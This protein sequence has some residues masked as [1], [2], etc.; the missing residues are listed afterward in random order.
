[1]WYWF[2]M[3]A[4]T[5]C[6]LTTELQGP[7]IVNFPL[8]SNST[9]FHIYTFKRTK[10]NKGLIEKNIVRL[11]HDLQVGGPRMTPDNNTSRTHWRVGSRWGRLQSATHPR[12][13]RTVHPPRYCLDDDDCCSSWSWLQSSAWPSQVWSWCT[14]WCSCWGWRCRP[15]PR[16]TRT[17]CRSR[18][19]EKVP[20]LPE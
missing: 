9:V 6:V 15:P 2:I 12:Y 16:W 19:R 11:I 20:L 3:W 5:Y 18:P 10:I 8:F 13:D 4:K 1:M 7:I 14:W 17:W